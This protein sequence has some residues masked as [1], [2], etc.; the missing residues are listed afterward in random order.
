MLPT[1][2]RLNDPK[3]AYFRLTFARLSIIALSLPLGAF[4]F[5]VIWSLFNDFVR[6]TFTH[7]D[8]ANYLPS[9]SAAIG[10]YEPQKTV[11]RLAVILHLP[12]RL[13]VAYMYLEYY[14]EHIKRNRRMFGILACTL[15]VIE[16]VA[17]FCLSLWTS[18][19]NYEIH[20]NSFV[21]F[22]ASS[23]C[24]MLISYLL[25]RSA[26][27]S[28]LLP[29]EEK[30]LR[31]KRNLFLV[32]VLAFGLAGYCFMRHNARCEAGVYTFF[33]LFEYIVVLT[34]MGFHMTAYWD[35]YAFS[36][37]CDA[38]NGLHISRS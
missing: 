27:K 22:I 5:C 11:W 9:V 37:V 35:F 29:H 21:V 12:L 3:N 30:S 13:T 10:N 1:Y 17:L 28:V 32:N 26:R 19:D 34:N 31:H 16:N 24:Y 38:R 14:R 33:A 15:N 36:I 8:V 7:C 2:E 6:S 4:S 20:R 18:A 25:N 23:E